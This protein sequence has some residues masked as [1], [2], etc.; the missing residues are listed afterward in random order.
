MLIKDKTRLNATLWSSS[1]TLPFCYEANLS[2]IPSSF[3]Q[4]LAAAAAMA[5]IRQLCR[6]PEAGLLAR[7][8]GRSVAQRRPFA[9]AALLCDH[10]D[11]YS[12][13]VG[14]RWPSPRAEEAAAETVRGV[15]WVL[16]GDPGVQKHVYAARL[17]RLLQVP[18][19]N[20]GCLVRQELYPRSSLYKQVAFLSQS[21]FFSVLARCN[22]LFWSTLFNFCCS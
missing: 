18:H 22:G 8:V 6:L 15:Q 4:W 11:E 13:E 10:D 7:H 2:T 14:R 3:G 9:A 1:K 5:G 21:F 20:M 19:I 16:I 12:T 17:S